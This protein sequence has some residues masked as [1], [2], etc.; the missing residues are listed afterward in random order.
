MLALLYPACCH[1]EAHDRA[2]FLPCVVSD[3]S[4]LSG[5]VIVHNRWRTCP[6][7]SCGAGG[8]LD[9][10]WCLLPASRAASAAPAGRAGGSCFLN[11]QPL[12]TIPS[13]LN[14]RRPRRLALCPSRSKLGLKYLAPVSNCC[15]LPLSTPPAIL[16]NKYDVIVPLRLPCGEAVGY[17]TNRVVVSSLVTHHYS[18][19]RSLRGCWI[20]EAL[21]ASGVTLSNLLPQKLVY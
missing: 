3:L 15:R 11:S 13:F 12:T 8:L 4:G 19:L 10:P 21:K 14:W 5:P 18:H 7:G 6:R 16:S 20:V 9:L 2:P 1:G 17:T